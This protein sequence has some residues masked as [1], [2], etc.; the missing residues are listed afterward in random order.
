MG[1]SLDLCFSV[2][3]LLEDTIR[4]ETSLVSVMAVNNEIGVKQPMK[5]I[6]VLRYYVWCRLWRVNIR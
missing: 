1:T 6:G 4:H 2:P 3:Q 5:E